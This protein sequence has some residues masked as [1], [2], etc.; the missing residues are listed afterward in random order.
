MC[1]D[2]IKLTFIDS[3]THIVIMSQMK[4]DSYEG[5]SKSSEPNVFFNI[6]IALV[7]A[8]LIAISKFFD[9]CRIEKFRLF[10]QPLFA[11]LSLSSIENL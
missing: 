11:Y 5:Q 3:L 1:D 7:N 2:E 4:V 6:I 10:L 9:A 8:K